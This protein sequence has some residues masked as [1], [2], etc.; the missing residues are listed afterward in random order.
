MLT[1]N[2]SI[3]QEIHLEVICEHQ[4]LINSKETCWWSSRL[5]RKLLC[6]CYIIRI[7]YDVWKKLCLSKMASDVDND[8]SSDHNDNSNNNDYED[9]DD[10][11]MVMTR[12]SES[13]YGSRFHPVPN[14]INYETRF[15]YMLCGSVFNESLQYTGSFH[16]RVRDERGWS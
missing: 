2:I 13:L 15:I 6:S 10:S 1:E 5:C 16:C 3:V 14:C 8:K 9:N 7:W 12:I 11:E 4:W